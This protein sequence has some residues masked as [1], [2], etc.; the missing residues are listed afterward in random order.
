[1]TH[2]GE[3]DYLMAKFGINRQH[4]IDSLLNSAGFDDAI[5]RLQCQTASRIPSISV[6]Y[7]APVPKKLAR[8]VPASAVIGTSNEDAKGIDKY[9]RA[10]LGSE[11][12]N[13]PSG[14]EE[15]KGYKGPKILPKPY[16]RHTSDAA[17]LTS[18]IE[19]PIRELVDFCRY[20]IDHEKVNPKDFICPI[21]Q[22]EYYDDML[23]LPE[24]DIDDLNTDML[25]S[26]SPV[27]TVML[28]K[29]ERHFFHKDCIEAMVKNSTSLKCPL[30]GVIYGIVLGD[31]PPGHMNCK[32][33]HASCKG[34]E[35]CGSVQIDYSFRPG[36]ING[37][38]YEGT[39]R[40]AYLPDNAE[41]NKVLRLLEIAF[42]RR[43]LFT[44][45]TS[46]TTGAQHTI[47]WNGVHHKTA[48]SGGAAMH[49]Y[50]DPTYLQR[51]KEE[52]AAKG[53]C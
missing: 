47:V 21:C 3:I 17:K 53:V 13:T 51:V 48:L 42:D 28:S 1:M 16:T 9:K 52:L 49:G 14:K 24:K 43:L 19:V 40:T 22:M 36:V 18:W 7:S 12:K 6:C 35:M 31:M 39:H 10:K 37:M 33:I 4:A 45:G 44:V 11:N 27:A 5:D 38:R 41:G 30:C 15:E 50:P 25:T 46:I 32:R 8:H 23:A 2:F 29:C 26:R 20:Q 34:Y